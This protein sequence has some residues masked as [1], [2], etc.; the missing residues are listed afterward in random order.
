MTE[1]FDA[2][3]YWDD[4]HAKTEGLEGVGY[5]GL[6]AFNDWMYRVRARV[7]RRLLS[8]YRE[9][10]RR[11]RVLD[12]GSGTG[13]YLRLW[14]E[15]GAKEIVGCDLSKVACERLR[16]EHR[17][18]E[19]RELDIGAASAD[20]LEALGKFDFISVMDVLYHVVDDAAYARSFANIARLLAPGG[21]LV[22]TE[23]FLVHRERTGNAW[24]VSRTLAEIEA[25][26]ARADLEI[27]RRSPWFVV[28]NNPIDSTSRALALG[29]KLIDRTVRRSRLAG[30]ALGAALYP[31]EITL[32][33]VLEE[34]PSSEIALARLAPK[35]GGS[36]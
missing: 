3:R 19:I 2:R 30:R 12:V 10:V 14:R 33:R 23:N 26:L 21:L 20:Q 7:F 15:L 13:F 8:P 1:A 35:R 5:L 22:F 31:I 36:A 9:K 6:G 17:D 11:A 16:S 4:R 27:L 28:M 32:T 29:W 25:V 24:Q 34:S 18:L